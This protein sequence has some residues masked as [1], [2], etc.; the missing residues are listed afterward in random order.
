MPINVHAPSSLESSIRLSF[1]FL[2]WGISATLTLILLIALGDGTLFSKILLGIVAIAL[3][4]AKL[5]SWRKGGAYRIYAVAL[6]ILSGIASLGASLRVVEESKGSFLAIIREDVQSSPTY[7]AQE[8]ELASID[9][10]IT[11]LI[12]HLKDLPSDYTTAAMRTESS[13]ASLRDRKQQILAS[14]SSSDSVGASYSDGNMIVLLARTVGLHPDTLLLV[15]LLF[16]SASIEIGALLLTIHE[17]RI[18]QAVEA[19]L[20]PSVYVGA[21]GNAATTE[22]A[23]PPAAYVTPMTPEAFLEAAMDGADLPFLHGRD[24]TAEKLGIS[25]AEAKRLV[26]KLIEEGRIIVEGKRLRLVQAQECGIL[27]K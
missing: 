20:C 23:L 25:Y 8:G 9:T 4:G 6:I 5:L 7:L 16:V 19:S 21:A 22:P 2:L 11:A 13:L 18:E 26:G 17:R 27:A 12:A 14:L 24:R 1:G 3:E 10:E 15:L